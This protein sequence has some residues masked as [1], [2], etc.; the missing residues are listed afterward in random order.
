MHMGMDMNM[1]MGMHI[2]PRQR[3]RWLEW[4]LAGRTRGNAS[5]RCLARGRRRRL[6]LR[7]TYRDRSGISNSTKTKT[8]PS[9]HPPN[10]PTTLPTHTHTR[11]TLACCTTGKT[12]VRTKRR[13]Y[14]VYRLRSCGCLCGRRLPTGTLMPTPMGMGMRMRARGGRVGVRV[15]IRARWCLRGRMRVRVL[16]A[17]RWRMRL[18]LGVV[19]VGGR[20]S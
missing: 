17:R 1:G 14:R 3:R 9:R 4:G 10:T 20:G 11:A 13:C 7:G 6:L 18:G 19:G 5:V 8:P 15:R 2:R 12:C 16:R